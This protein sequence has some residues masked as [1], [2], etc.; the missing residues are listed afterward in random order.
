[1]RLMEGRIVSVLHGMAS[2]ERLNTFQRVCELSEELGDDSSLIRGTVFNCIGFLCVRQLRGEAL[3]AQE[4]ARP[5]PGTGPS[6]IRT[7]RCFPRPLV[8]LARCAYTAG[9]WGSRRGFS[10]LSE[11]AM[12]SGFSLPA[13]PELQQIPYHINLWS[14][15]LLHYTLLSSWRSADPMKRSNSAMSR[16]AAPANSSHPYI[17]FAWAL[18]F[19]A[20]LHSQRREPEAVRSLAEAAIALAEE[21][22]LPERMAEGRLFRGW[23]MAELGQTEQAL[24]DLEAAD[25]LPLSTSI[26]FS[27]DRI[28]LGIYL[29]GRPRRQGTRPAQGEPCQT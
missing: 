29:A 16:C 6:R 20:I 22:G 7:A 17:P 3:T 11:L 4:A 19:A 21:H 8:L 24:A 25:R 28:V 1:M 13:Y 5:M 2:T 9:N 26:F 23:A 27:S 10:L 12:W 14:F 18:A 15:V